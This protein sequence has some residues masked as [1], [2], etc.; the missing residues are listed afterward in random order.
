MCILYIP[1]IVY[2]Y[3]SLRFG[4]VLFNLEGFQYPNKLSNF[5]KTHG[6]FQFRLLIESVEIG[7]WTVQCWHIFRFYIYDISNVYW[8][9]E[10]ALAHSANDFNLKFI[11]TE[12]FLIL[13]FWFVSSVCSINALHMRLRHLSHSPCRSVP[14]FLLLPAGDKV[15]NSVDKHTHTHTRPEWAHCNGMQCIHREEGG[16]L[17]NCCRC[18]T[19]R[20]RNISSLSLSAFLSLRRCFSA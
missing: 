3:F 5:P 16:G 14:A 6:K 2:S 1:A 10:R 8:S 15:A 12:I 17:R 9:S 18:T 4:S 20:M 11:H 7:L 13:Y 19:W